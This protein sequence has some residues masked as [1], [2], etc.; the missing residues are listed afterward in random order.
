MKICVVTMFVTLVGQGVAFAQTA[1]PPC[2]SIA[3]DAARLRCYDEMSKSA[4]STAPQTPATPLI[5]WKIE[6]QPSPIDDKP[7]V[8]ANIVSNEKKLILALR[9]KENRTEVIIAPDIYVG[10][11]DDADVTYRINSEPAVRE[12]WSSSTNGRAAFSP[13]AIVFA[14][15][16]PDNGKLFFRIDGFNGVR[17]QDTFDLGNVTAARAKVSAACGWK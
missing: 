5:E 10:S 6:E 11:S 14:R 17:S 9:C 4:P 3:D 16:L 12:K 13:Q 7:E 15:K 2:P 8:Y 1:A